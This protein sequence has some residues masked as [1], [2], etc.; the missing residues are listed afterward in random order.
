MD[1]DT[2]LGCLLVA[3]A[4]S[5]VTYLVL[6]SRRAINRIAAN[7]RRSTREIVKELRRDR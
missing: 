6:W 1:T 2:L 4:L 7:D 5:L 3:S